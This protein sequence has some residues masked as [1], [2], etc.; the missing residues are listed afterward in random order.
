MPVKIE[1]ELKPFDVPA[2]VFIVQAAQPRQGGFSTCLSFELKD[3]DSD[4]LEKLCYEFTESIF[5]A[6]GKTRAMTVGKA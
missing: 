3:L 5:A 6:A 2:R 4:T 1:T